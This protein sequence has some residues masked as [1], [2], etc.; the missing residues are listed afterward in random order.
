MQ[1]PRDN[2]TGSDGLS[3]KQMEAINLLCAG[4]TQVAVADAIKVH[5]VT[6][7]NWVRKDPRFRAELNR[8]LKEHAEANAVR[9][10]NLVEASLEVMET[11]IKR[12]RDPRVA[13]QILRLAGAQG[14]LGG[15]PAGPAT[16]EDAALQIVLEDEHQS[17]ALRLVLAAT[18]PTKPRANIIDAV[19]AGAKPAEEDDAGTRLH[20]APANGKGTMGTIKG[21]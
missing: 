9:M 15:P 10:Q 13:T 14:Y 16:F 11:S 5:R 12:D 18:K 3:P 6:V 8:R 19:I 17:S 7:S 20:H 21:T 1:E 2:I 4:Q